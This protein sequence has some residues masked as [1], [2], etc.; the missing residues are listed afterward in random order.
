MKLIKQFEEIKLNNF[1]MVSY[2]FTYLLDAKT[3]HYDTIQC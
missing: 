3:H 2:L 1:L